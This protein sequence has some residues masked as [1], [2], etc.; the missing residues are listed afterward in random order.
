MG[1]HV[2]RTGDN[3]QQV[4]ELVPMTSGDTNQLTLAGPTSHKGIGRS[5]LAPARSV[6]PPST[7]PH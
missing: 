4:G 2:R 1:P 7:S 6:G 5:P 3:V